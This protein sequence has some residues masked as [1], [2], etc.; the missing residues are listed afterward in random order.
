MRIQR[1][2]CRCLSKNPS[3]VL[4]TL[5]VPFCAAAAFSAF[6]DAEPSS[7]LHSV[8]NAVLFGPTQRDAEK[9]SAERFKNS[10]L[11]I[12]GLQRVGVLVQM[13]HPFL[14]RD[15]EGVWLDK[16]RTLEAE[17]HYVTQSF[18][19]NNVKTTGPVAPASSS[20]P[21]QVPILPALPVF[22]GDPTWRRTG[23]TCKTLLVWHKTNLSEA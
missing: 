22:A 21:K 16:W 20:Q 10:R 5:C 14:S 17:R 3:P 13:A 19:S 8:V 1:V 9:L 11:E 15:S 6:S 4:V 7:A 18:Y 23:M 2:A 12:A